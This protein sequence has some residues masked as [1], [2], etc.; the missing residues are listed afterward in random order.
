MKFILE[1]AREVSFST[2]FFSAAN[3]QSVTVLSS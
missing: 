2:K 1:S 3:S